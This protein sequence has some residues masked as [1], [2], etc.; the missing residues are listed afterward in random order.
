MLITQVIKPTV[1]VRAEKAIGSGTIVYSS[2][3]EDKVRTLVLTCHHVI[4]GLISTQAVWNSLLGRKVRR[5]IRKRA[6]VVNFTYNQN[7]ECV[8]STSYNARI[9]A[10]DAKADLALLELEDTEHLFPYVADVISIQKYNQLVHPGIEVV[11]AGSPNGYPIVITKG[12]LSF[13]GIEIANFP[14][15]IISSCIFSG[16]SGGSVMALVGD[17]Y[18]FIG[19][20]AR[21][22]VSQISMFSQQIVTHVGFSICFKT[23]HKFLTE[24]YYRFILDKVNFTYQSEK[25]LR[26][27]FIRKEKAKAEYFERLEKQ[28]LPEYM[29]SEVPD[30]DLP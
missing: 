11:A 9:V 2:K 30:G 12:F 7:A 28:D 22:A 15:N 17:S 23:I 24:N 1:L 21:V 4:E 6:E 13:K 14:Y 18:K 27:Q 3:S 8:G 29:R 10:Y 19:I 20:V 26:E 16:N 25:K 5:E